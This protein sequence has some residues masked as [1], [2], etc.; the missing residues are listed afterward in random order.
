M[1]FSFRSRSTTHKKNGAR[2]AGKS[3]FYR[4]MEILSTEV[5]ESD[6]VVFHTE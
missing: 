3:R 2:L 6:H 1:G 5:V 4:L